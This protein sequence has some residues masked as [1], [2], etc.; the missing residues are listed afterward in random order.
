MSGPPD[1]GPLG[2][3]ALAA[4]PGYR[5]AFHGS[6]TSFFLIFLKNVLLTLL[7]LG[8]YLAWAKTER[9]RYIWHNI[10]FHGQ[11]LGYTGK[12]LELFKG[13][14]VVVAGYLLFIGLPA[15]A[16]RFAP[17]LAGTVE[18]ALGIGLFLA[19]PALIY[20]S[21]AFLYSR[22]TW[23]SIRFGLVPGAGARQ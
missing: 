10:E 6:G 23:R 11:H 3:V 4:H 7:T 13:Y 16:A 15:L 17:G 2:Q 5:F 14:L 8:I 21:R 19:I 12:G 22:T 18:A 1:S 9:R 20:R